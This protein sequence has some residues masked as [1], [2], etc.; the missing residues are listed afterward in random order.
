MQWLIQRR[1]RDGQKS[2][3]ASERERERERDRKKQRPGE[4]ERARERGPDRQAQ[5]TQAYRIMLKGRR[6]CRYRRRIINCHVETHERRLIRLR[7]HRLDQR[8]ERQPITGACA[9]SNVH[10]IL[11]SLPKSGHRRSRHG[12][13]H[14]LSPAHSILGQLHWRRERSTEEKHNNTHNAQAEQ[15][16]AESCPRA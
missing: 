3:R 12:R 10:N 13:L 2:E 7:Q 11:A 9:Y 5:D 16:P 14:S 6:Q 8:S 1:R 15:K 4:S